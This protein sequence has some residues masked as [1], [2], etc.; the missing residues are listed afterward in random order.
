MRFYDRIQFAFSPHQATR[1]LKGLEVITDYTRAK[2]LQIG[3]WV[4]PCSAGELSTEYIKFLRHFY[5]F[6]SGWKSWDNNFA[7]N[8]FVHSER[9]KRTKR[10]VNRR[11]VHHK[12]VGIKKYFTFIFG[13]TSHK[14]QFRALLPKKGTKSSFRSLNGTLEGVMDLW[15]W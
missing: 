14:L 3:L 12:N 7:V 15:R 9:R 10:T 5:S 6:F 11:N 1:K 2:M 4:I 8:I 13:R